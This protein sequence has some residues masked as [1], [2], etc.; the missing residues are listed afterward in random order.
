LVL[1]KIY[2]GPNSRE[3]NWES[4]ERLEFPGPNSREVELGRSNDSQPRSS[5]F[6]NIPIFPRS[7]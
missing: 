5:D 2:L 6:S 3:R 7:P 1:A 4:F